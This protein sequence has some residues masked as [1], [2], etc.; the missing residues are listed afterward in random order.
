MK[1]LPQPFPPLSLSLPPP[2][3]GFVAFIYLF[4]YLF[5]LIQPLLFSSRV[6]IY[7]WIKVLIAIVGLGT[8]VIT[9]YMAWKKCR[10]NNNVANPNNNVALANPGLELQGVWNNLV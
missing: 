8:A 5:Y 4:I 1:K 9:F 3:K 7:V 2:Q 10:R 6:E